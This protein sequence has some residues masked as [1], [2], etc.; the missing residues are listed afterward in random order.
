MYDMHRDGP[1]VQGP[2]PF[3]S[4]KGA[5]EGESRRG[6]PR[7]LGPALLSARTMVATVHPNQNGHAAAS[8]VRTAE[9][10]DYI[11]H[12]FTV[13]F[14]HLLSRQDNTLRSSTAVC[15][16]YTHVSRL[17]SLRRPLTDRQ[18][19]GHAAHKTAVIS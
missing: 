3:R 8:P 17:R 18:A 16:P 5:S 10:T 13:T 19:T 9:S 11:F 1:S 7:S 15:K 2:L 6:Y 4:T 12:S 14:T